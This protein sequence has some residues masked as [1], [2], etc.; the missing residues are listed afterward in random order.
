MKGGRILLTIYLSMFDTEQ[1]RKKMM[2]L[3]E[4]HKYASYTYRAFLWRKM[5]EMDEDFWRLR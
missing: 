4:E 2:D 5:K 3:Y 1:E